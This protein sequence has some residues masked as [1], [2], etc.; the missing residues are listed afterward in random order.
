[1]LVMFVNSHWRKTNLCFDQWVKKFPKGL[2]SINNRNSSR[3][4]MNRPL[5]YMVKILYR[6]LALN[7][8]EINQNWTVATV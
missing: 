3:M 7:R 2:F 1:M 5:I 4:Y 6:I 8:C